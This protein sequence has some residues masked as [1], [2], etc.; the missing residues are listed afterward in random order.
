VP[1]SW[2]LFSQNL[3]SITGGSEG[4][5]ATVYVYNNTNVGRWVDNVALEER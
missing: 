4:I 1:T 2:Q 5:K 3:A